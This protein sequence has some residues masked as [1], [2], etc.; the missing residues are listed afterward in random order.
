MVGRC[1]EMIDAVLLK[2]C[3]AL[4]LSHHHEVV[5]AHHIP[6]HQRRPKMS[7]RVSLSQNTR[8]CISTYK[9]TLCPGADG[10][11]HRSGLS[12]V[13]AAKSA[14]FVQR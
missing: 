12:A 2:C 13:F 4:V 6:P 11:R 14:T 3:H 7:S 5:N 8:Y 10:S 9:T 1:L